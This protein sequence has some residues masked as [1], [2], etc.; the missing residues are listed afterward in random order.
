[1]QRFRAE[2][3]VAG[4]GPAGLTAAR[5]LAH[6][7]RKVVVIDPGSR[8]AKRLELLAPASLGTI[9]ALGLSALLQDPAIARPCLGIRRQWDKAEVEY[10]DFLRHP[11]RTGYVVDRAA[12]DLRL[13][14]AAAA[15]GV[16]FCQARVT[17]A[18]AGGVRVQAGDSGPA[19]MACS[20]AVIDA[21]GRAAMIARRNG[22]RVTL[23]DRMVAELVEQA[24]IK[25]CENTPGWLDV[26]KHGSSWSYRIHGPAGQVQTWRIRRSAIRPAANA[27]LRV[28]ASASLLSAAA[29]EGWIVVGDAACAFDP[30]ASQGLFNALSSALVATGALLSAEGLTPAAARLYSDAVAAT[31]AWS[32]AGRSNVY[33]RDVHY[34]LSPMG[35]TKEEPTCP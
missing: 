13:H 26:A 29:G 17:G 30:I 7:G 31:F 27:L 15:A 19:I 24:V 22:A 8:T 18:D 23:R 1:L 11:Y 33:G 14:A 5:L 10:E 20:H 25:S 34:G 21:T 6:R 35:T 28:D 32:E 16:Q 3:L 12:F 4:A 2:Y 9:A